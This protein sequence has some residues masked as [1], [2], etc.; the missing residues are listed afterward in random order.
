M[1]KIKYSIV[2]LAGLLTLAG[3]N[4]SF[5]DQTPETDITEKNFF[6]TD[7]DLQLYSNK[8][9]DYFYKSTLSLGDGVSDNGVCGNTTDRLYLYMSGGVTPDNVGKWGWGDIRNVNFMIARSGKATGDNAKHYIGLA[10]L[11]R[12]KLYYDKVLTYSNVPWYSRDLQTNDDEL[13]YKTQ[14]SRATV[15][16]SILADLDYAI[17]N[18]KTAAQMGGHSYATKDL[19]LAVKAHICLSEASW[20]KYHAELSLKDADRFYKEAISACE[21]LMGMGYA[22]SPDYHTLFCNTSLADNPEA[23]FYKDYD[24]AN[25][26][27]WCY[28]DLFGCNYG[29]SKDMFDTFLYLTDDGRA[30]P[31]TSIKGY[32]TKSMAEGF[33]N[34]DPRLKLQ[35]VY[36]GYCRPATPTTPFRQ[37]LNTNQGYSVCKWEPMVNNGNTTGYGSGDCCFGDVAY[38]RYAE[39]LLIYA[40]AKAEL[41]QLTQADLDKTI[42]LLR[43]RVGMPHAQLSDWLA[44]VDPV[45]AQKYPNVTGSQRGAILEVRRERRVELFQEGMRHDD[46][47]RWALGK[48]FEDLGKG[49]YVGT[50]FPAEV[51]RDGDGVAD[52]A[53]VE[54]EAQK[55]AEQAKGLTAFIIGTDGFQI[56]SDGYIEPNDEK[57]KYTFDTK[58]YYTPVSSQDIVVNPN[59]VQNPLWK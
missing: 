55:A 20:R 18:M 4:D 21:Q 13:L 15:C 2:L 43:D 8:F 7:A 10:R 50:K 39:I 37:M 40:E 32:N 57:G 49:I 48:A 11:T 25:S 27:L 31:Y 42:N 58:C 45:L 22:L 34:R 28:N 36:P 38:Y 54:N 6:K 9:Y 1:D 17:A 12:A 44:N 19:A 3:C 26:I 59:L 56:S 51:D 33:K 30:V 53:I 46:L 47:F 41:G 23:I 5:L 29:V 35:L 14:D 16:D 24:R 52:A